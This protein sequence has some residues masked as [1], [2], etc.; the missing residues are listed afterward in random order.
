M[1]D[2]SLITGCPVRAALFRGAYLHCMK[3]FPAGPGPTEEIREFRG[4]RLYIK[5]DDLIHPEFG[6]NKWRKLKYNIVHMSHHGLNRLVTFGGPFSNHIYATAACARHFGIES[7]GLIR[8]ET[9]DRDNPVIR[10]AEQCG[11]QLMPVSRRIFAL[12]N[13]PEYLRGLSRTY[14]PAHFIPEGGS[15]MS[16]AIGCTGI[17][18]EVMNQLGFL[19]QHWI[20]PG[21]TGYTAAGIAYGL[22][23]RATVHLVASVKRRFIDETLNA[24]RRLLP[25]PTEIKL[26]DAYHFG[27][28]AKWDVSLIRT[29]RQCATDHDIVLDPLYTGKAWYAMLA[30]IG[31]GNIAQGESVLFVH[32][33]GAPGTAGFTYRFGAIL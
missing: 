11:M 13:S 16:G 26:Y 21:G 18:R 22:R 5:R 8:G 4:V 25:S 10:F 14:G 6:G 17:V 31:S 19:P 30:L 27:G 32:T 24:I 2:N 23:A 33:G 3:N 7:I 20:V 9:L 15:N 1:E 12:R 28:L 29:M